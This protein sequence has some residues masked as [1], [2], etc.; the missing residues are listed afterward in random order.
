SIQPAAGGDGAAFADGSAHRYAHDRQLSVD[1]RASG[2]V[3]GAL[4]QHAGRAP[5]ARHECVRASADSGARWSSVA[6]RGDGRPAESDG[7]GIFA[8]G[9]VERA[10]V[11]TG[12]NAEKLPRRV[13]LHFLMPHGD[14]E[15]PYPRIDSHQHFTYEILPSL[16]WP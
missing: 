12:R 9:D 14:G 11:A 13:E 4:V 5:V 10:A 3:A 2:G 16:L 8:A 7:A 1:E 6:G 15:S